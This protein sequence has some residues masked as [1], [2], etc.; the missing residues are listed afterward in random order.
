MTTA[1]ESALRLAKEQAAREEWERILIDAD[2]MPD[3][4]L[5]PH[6]NDAAVRWIADQIDAIAPDGYQTGPENEDASPTADPQTGIDCTAERVAPALDAL[7]LSGEELPLS[8]LDDAQDMLV[9]WLDEQGHESRKRVAERLIQHIEA[10]A[11]TIAS[12]SAE[13]ESAEI[14]ATNWFVTHLSHREA[15]DALGKANGELLKR[16]IEERDRAEAAESSLATARQEGFEECRRLAT[17]A[18]DENASAS[19]IVAPL[20]NAA[21]DEGCRD[22]AVLIAALTPGGDNET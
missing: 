5:P 16:V 19:K 21:Y 15:L 7:L 22:C 18:C 17:T 3:E 6:L 10:D 2:I 11:A 9:N 14:N 20:T 1:A 4:V 12:L 13:R 8:L